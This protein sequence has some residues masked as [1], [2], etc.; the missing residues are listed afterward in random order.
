MPSL[1][2]INVLLALSYG[3]HTHHRATASWLATIN[4]AGAVVVQ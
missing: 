3:R 1:C 4:D 2:D